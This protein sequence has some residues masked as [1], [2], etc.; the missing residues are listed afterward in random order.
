MIRLLAK[1]HNITLFTS[2]SGNNPEAE[3]IEGINII[4]RGGKYSVYKEAKEYTK[5]SKGD[6]DLIIDEINAKPFLGP[7]M[8]NGTPIMAL[9][10]Q[11]IK[12]EW[13]YET[14]FPLNLICYYFLERQWLRPYR[15]TPTITVSMSSKR[16]LESLGFRQI[17]LVPNGLSIKPL[18]NLGNKETHPTIIFIGR[19]KK[20]KLPNHAIAAFR[21]IKNRLKD[22]R[23]WVIGEGDMKTSLERKTPNGVTFFGRVSDSQKYDLLSRAHLVLMPSVREGWGQVVTES[24]AMGTPVIGYDVPGLRDSIQNGKTGVLSPFNSPPVMA[25]HAMHLLENKQMLDN[26]SH[27]ALIY[28][29]QFSWDKSAERFNQIICNLFN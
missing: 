29:K 5:S 26:Y 8:T 6:Y 18:E 12:E 20:H 19:L 23:M 24:N 7:E 25:S 17:Y 10:H 21:I 16:D 14:S 2:R 9:F 15:N 28:A 3:S 13:F 11:L 22:S 27:Q 4:R 1:G